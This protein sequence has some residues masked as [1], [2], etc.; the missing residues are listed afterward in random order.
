MHTQIIKFMSIRIKIHI[1]TKLI[2][3]ISIIRRDETFHKSLVFIA[4]ESSKVSGDPALPRNLVRT[5]A[6]HR[7][8]VG[9]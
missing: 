8:K 4:Y 6:V 3:F 9:T 1:K 5:I 2:E 7:D